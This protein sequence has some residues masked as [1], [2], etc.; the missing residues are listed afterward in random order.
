MVVD[1]QAM[2]SDSTVGQVSIISLIAAMLTP[3]L[4]GLVYIF[5]KKSKGAKMHY[6]K[7]S[8]WYSTFGMVVTTVYIVVMIA[9]LDLA[10]KPY[11]SVIRSINA[12]ECTY[13]FGVAFLGAIA[14]VS[15]SKATQIINTTVASLIRNGDIIFT[16]LFQILYYK[17]I[18]SLIQV[19]GIITMVLSTVGV[20]LV[21]ERRRIEAEKNAGKEHEEKS[22]NVDNDIM[23]FKSLLKDEEK[24][25]CSR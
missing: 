6:I 4:K 10:G 18:P 5:I 2:S 7:L 20:I 17:E 9:I 21:K 19:A 3:L 8:V 22:G 1:P 24:G 13:V 23:A 12:S 14:Q 15:M 11:D 25:R 16:I